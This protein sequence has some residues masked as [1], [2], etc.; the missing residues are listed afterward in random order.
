MEP[1]FVDPE[2]L[3]GRGEGCRW[4][5]GLKPLVRWI[6]WLVVVFLVQTEGEVVGGLES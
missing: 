3:F 1:V 6:P 4:H 2:R 5:G